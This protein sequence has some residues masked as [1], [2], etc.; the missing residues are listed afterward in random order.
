MSL[1]IA[2]RMEIKNYG[3]KNIVMIE[4]IDCWGTDEIVCPHCGYEYSESHEYL[5][6][7]MP[8]QLKLNCEN[9][10]GVFI[11]TPEYSLAYY[12]E[13]IQKGPIN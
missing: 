13:I 4:E 10:S 1:S 12:S 7:N 11:C 6:D 8:T 2:R 3:R 9:C 5:Q